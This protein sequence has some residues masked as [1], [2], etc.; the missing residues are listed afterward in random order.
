MATLNGYK[1]ENLYKYAIWGKNPE[2]L[3]DLNDL[4]FVQASKWSQVAILCP[5]VNFNQS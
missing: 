3:T 4:S 2:D 1:Y 5:I